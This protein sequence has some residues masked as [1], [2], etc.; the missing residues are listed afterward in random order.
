MPITLICHVC[1]KPYQAKAA[2]RH[3]SKTC[4]RECQARFFSRP[5]ETRFWEKVDKDGPIIRPELGPC[6][7]W[8]GT[9]AGRSKYGRFRTPG[10][11]YGYTLAHRFSYELHI[12]TIE[13]DL[14]VCHKCDNPPCVN[15]EHFFLGTIADNNHDRLL[16]GRSYTHLTAEQVIEVRR[17]RSTGLSYSKIA[18]Q[19]GVPND[20][21]RR[22][23]KSWKH[24]K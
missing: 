5:A 8:T 15:P 4:S 3:R 10:K 17:L 22:A 23:V 21:V 13:D 12:G 11:G 1:G 19:Y 24:I 18:A 7:V 6:W 2:H 20:A 16:K 14:N 9:F